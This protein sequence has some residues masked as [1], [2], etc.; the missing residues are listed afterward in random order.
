MISRK[1][2]HRIRETEN[3]AG[4]RKAPAEGR[5]A[6]ARASTPERDRR[7]QGRAYQIKEGMVPGK[8]ALIS[9][10]EPT[11]NR[12]TRQNCS[13][14]RGKTS[15]RKKEPPPNAWRKPRFFLGERLPAESRRAEKGNRATMPERRLERRIPSSG[16]GVP[17]TDSKV[18]E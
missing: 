6:E 14:P 1:M 4:R 7:Y 15:S 10:R 2:G 5:K 9:R 11:V 8:K 13:S 12:K 3:T 16:A 17:S 18:K